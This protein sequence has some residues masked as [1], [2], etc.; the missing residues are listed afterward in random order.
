ML[1]DNI[2]EA[3]SNQVNAEIESAYLYLAMSAYCDRT[4]FSG[5]ANWMRIQAQEEMAH[6]MH[7]YEHILERGAT[8]DLKAIAAPKSTFENL[9]EVFAATLAH[10]QYVTGLIN[11]IATLAMKEEDHATYGFMQWYINE[12]V[13]EESTADQVLQKLTHIGDN[14]GMLYN[15]DVEMS[16]RVFVDPFAGQA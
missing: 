16:T 14:T 6:G 4:G 1:K 8:P 12:Q 7:I 11:T 5:F 3:L 2:S 9:N 13:E 15:M 10:E